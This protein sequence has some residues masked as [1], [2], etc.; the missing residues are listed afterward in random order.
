MKYKNLLDLVVLA[1]G[2]GSRMKSKTLPKPLHSLNGIPMINYLLNNLKGC[3]MGSL[4]YLPLINRSSTN[5]LPCQ[6]RF[7]EII[8]LVIL[9]ALSN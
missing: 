8:S 1:A 5:R 9:E 2:K 3:P 7:K 4:F 6:P